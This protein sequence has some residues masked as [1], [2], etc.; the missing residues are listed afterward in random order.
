[1]LCRAMKVILFALLIS[2]IF[3]PVSTVFGSTIAV[4]AVI[5]GLLYILED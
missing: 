2:I 4:I 1:M 3:A 5:L